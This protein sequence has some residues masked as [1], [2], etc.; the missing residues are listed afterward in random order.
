MKTVSVNSPLKKCPYCGSSRRIVEIPNLG[1]IPECTSQTC[2]DMKDTLEQAI[3]YNN[4]R[5]L[6]DA[7]DK[8]INDLYKALDDLQDYCDGVVMLH[9]VRQ[10]E[11][12]NHLAALDIKIQLYGLLAAAKLALSNGDVE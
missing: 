2:Y 7:K 6:E 10:A 1:F 12:D 8:I 4:T 5:P 11:Y 9:L 3:A